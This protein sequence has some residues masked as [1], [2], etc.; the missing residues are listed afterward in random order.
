ML[1][2]GLLVMMVGGRLNETK[3]DLSVIFGLDF[4]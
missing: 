1:I 4:E 2:L 3:R